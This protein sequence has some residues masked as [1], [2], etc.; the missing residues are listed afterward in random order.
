MHALSPEGHLIT[1]LLFMTGREDRLT[2][3]PIVDDLQLE[4]VRAIYPQLNA[5]TERQGRCDLLNRLLLTLG[6]K[7]V[8]PDFVETV[9]SG[10]DF[11]NPAQLA[12]AVDKFRTLCMLS[13]GSFR[14]GFRQFRQGKTVR[15]RWSEHFPSAEQVRLLEEQWR[16]RPAPVGLQR[17]QADQL[18]ALGYLAGQHATAINEARQKLRALL[19]AAAD[20][21]ATRFTDLLAQA[22]QAGVDDF[23]SLLSK[24]GVPGAAPLAHLDLPLFA[25]NASYTRILRQVAASCTTMSPEAIQETRRIGNQNSRMYMAMHDLDV[26]VATSMREPLHFTSNSTFVHRLFYEGDLAAWNVRYFDP[27]QSFL[28]DRVQKGLLE[29]LMIKRARLTVYNAQEEDTFGKDAEAGVTLAQGKPVIVFVAR[30]FEHELRELYSAIDLG[31]RADQEQFVDNLLAKGLLAADDREALLVPSSTKQHV[32]TKVIERH[33]PSRLASLPDEVIS[34]ELIRQGYDAAGHGG[35][36]KA[37]ALQKILKLERRALTFR[38]V[39][40]LSLQTS[41]LDGVARG[42]IVTRSVEQTARVIQGLFLG[43]LEYEIR[44]DKENWLLVDK[45]TGSPVRVVTKDALLTTAFWTEDWLTPDPTH[46]EIAGATAG[47]T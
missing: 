31:A 20:S 25:E 32:V 22:T 15:H 46:A 5:A 43:T 33:S 30:L 36:P 29:C 7:T 42:V 3:K 37:F 4:G 14:H 47:G 8:S 27:T 38:D 40:P 1:S 17:I 26:Y 10:V 39:H 12:G 34:M 45:I 18:F 44:N 11:G 16:A 6:I 13:Y 24:A 28:G 35:S 2:H 9:F 21:G 19:E 41:P 23:P